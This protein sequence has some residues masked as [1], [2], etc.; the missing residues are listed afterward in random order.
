MLLIEIGHYQSSGGWG[1]PMVFKGA[2]VGDQSSPMEW[3]NTLDTSRIL[4]LH[5]FIHTYIHNFTSVRDF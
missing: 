2:Q 5:T 1:D 4:I 3:V